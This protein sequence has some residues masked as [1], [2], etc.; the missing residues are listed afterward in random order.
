MSQVNLLE[1]VIDKAIA[2]QEAMGERILSAVTNDA[3]AAKMKGLLDESEELDRYQLAMFCIAT[4][5]LIRA[6]IEDD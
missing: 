4:R 5:K 2:E 6:A 3:I 1:V